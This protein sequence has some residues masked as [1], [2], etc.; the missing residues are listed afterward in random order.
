MTNE[1]SK[2]ITTPQTDRFNFR[3]FSQRQ[4]YRQVNRDFMRIA[5]GFIFLPTGS[6]LYLVDVAAGTGLVGQEAIDLFRETGTEARIF[7]TDP[8]MHALEIAR[9]DTP[10]DPLRPVTFIQGYGQDLKRILADRLPIG[11]AHWLSIHDAIH[12]IPDNDHET[13]DVKQ[14][15]ISSMAELLAKDG[16]LTLNTAFTTDGMG[17]AGIA[18]GRWIAKAHQI[19]GIPLSRTPVEVLK[20]EIYKSMVAKAG[21]TIVYDKPRPVT[22]SRKAL[23]AISMY[24]NFINGAITGEATQTIPLEQRSAALIQALEERKIE[25]LPRVW[26]EII[27]KKV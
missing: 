6:P 10:I 3:D 2:Y 8:D 26:Y 19:L 1:A 21:L 24:P 16:I 14:D 25:S 23:E 18:W 17:E 7:E 4:E 5:Y 27:G 15:V 22:L 11:G 9:Q 12:E 20:P 13:H